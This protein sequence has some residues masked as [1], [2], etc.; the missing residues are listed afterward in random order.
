MNLRL[1]FPIIFCCCAIYCSSASPPSDVEVDK[2]VD[3]YFAKRPS[4]GYG[5]GLSKDDALKTQER[6]VARLTPRLGK[7]IGYKVGL[8]TREAQQRFGVNSP[9]RGV[10]LERMLLKDG[11]Q[12]PA[13]FGA[14]PICEADLIVVVK[15]A[16]INQAKTPLDVA[17]HLKA[18]V[19]FIELPDGILATNRPI[20]GAQLIA[21][22]VGARLGVT[23]QRVSVKPTP[24]FVEAMASM[25]VTMTDQTG[26]ELGREPGRIILG[27]PLNAVVWLVGELNA[28]GEKLKAGDVLSLGSLKAITPQAGQTIT[29]RYGGLPGGTIKVSCKF[30]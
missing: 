13:N 14:R 2:V 23:G 24:D 18:V 28:H 12:V 4:Q 21:V 30:K 5:P 1:V 16:G 11:A 7:K 25:T 19:A 20:D 22:N 15:D 26:T 6:F 17:R 10:L 8:V 9:A 3:D 29:V 27:N